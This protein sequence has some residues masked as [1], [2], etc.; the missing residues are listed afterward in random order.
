MAIAVG[1][2]GMSVEDFERCTPSEFTEIGKIW[3]E[4]E[5]YTN[6]R[7]WEQTRLIGYSSLRPYL[8][9]GV[10]AEQ[11]FPLSWDG[12]KEN[13]A[14]EISKEEFKARY[15]AAKKKWGLK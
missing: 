6:K 4:R 8:K 9:P 13:T 14:N 3:L 2:I 15:A 12:K 10:T 11:I 1:C 5:E 7:T